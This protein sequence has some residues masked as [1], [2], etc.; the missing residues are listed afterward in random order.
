MAGF[1]IKAM[2]KVIIQTKEVLL[3]L[4]HSLNN[5]QLSNLGNYIQK[6]TQ[7]GFMLAQLRQPRLKLIQ[8]LLKNQHLLVAQT[9][10]LWVQF[11]HP[12]HYLMNRNT[13]F[14]PVFALSS[15]STLSVNKS[16]VFIH[17]GQTSFHGFNTLR[18]QMVYSLLCVSL[19]Q[20]SLQE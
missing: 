12:L 5:H 13:R 8:S 19:Q 17:T 2:T 15:R 3:I 11:L 4:V 20:S 16:G 14:S 9:P 18:H 10:I 1:K 6:Y 7:P